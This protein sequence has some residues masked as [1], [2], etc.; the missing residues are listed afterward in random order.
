MPTSAVD[1]VRC[2]VSHAFVA[3]RWLDC[4]SQY[5]R[6]DSQEAGRATLPAMPGAEGDRQSCGL[7]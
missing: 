2:M 5:R 1:E 3:Q 7:R 4:T 6:A